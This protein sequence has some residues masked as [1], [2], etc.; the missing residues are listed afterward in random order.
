MIC[1]NTCGLY[2]LCISTGHGDGK[3]TTAGKVR[4]AGANKNTCDDC[5][6]S[7]DRRNRNV[8]C[9]AAD[10]HAPLERELQ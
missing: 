3:G 2:P 5:N 10:V 8:A 1:Y 6:F 9:V 7:K 4:G